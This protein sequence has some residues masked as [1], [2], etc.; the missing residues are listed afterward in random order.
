MG[1]QCPFDPQIRATWAS[2]K[3]GLPVTAFHFKYDVAD[4]I[5]REAVEWCNELAHGRWSRGYYILPP[6]PGRWWSNL[7][8][9]F[10][11]K[12]VNDALLF[13]LTFAG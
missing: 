1:K 3:F 10:F 2:V 8:W 12:N 9:R 7:E 5:D 13:K 6:L 4:S 11:F